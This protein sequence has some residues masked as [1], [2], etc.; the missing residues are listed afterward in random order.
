[1]KKNM[2]YIIIGVVIAL[3][4]G[5]YFLFLQPNTFASE[6]LHMNLSAPRSWDVSPYED[7]KVDKF[8]WMQSM[9]EDQL[10]ENIDAC[11]YK[12]TALYHGETGVGRNGDKGFSVYVSKKSDYSQ[13]KTV[14][15]Y[16]NFIKSE[17]MS[18]D[19]HFAGS[20]FQKYEKV[21]IGD[22]ETLLM[23]MTITQCNVIKQYKV[24]AYEEGDYFVGI[25]AY[26]EHEEDWPLVDDVVMGWKLGK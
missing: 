3:L 9:N 10:N 5:G 18:Q 24:Y 19:N 17:T 8:L 13:A 26:V 15:D 4:I 1:M 20:Q 12:E 6:H 23:D 16:L 22:Q 7:Q 11:E 21:M 25:Y 2:R 14:K